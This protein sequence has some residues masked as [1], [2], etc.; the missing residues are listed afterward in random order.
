MKRLLHFVTV[1]FVCK[2]V[3]LEIRGSVM[4]NKLAKVKP[5]GAVVNKK[6]VPLTEFPP[7][8]VPHSHSGR[9]HFED[10]CSK[11]PPAQEVYDGNKVNII[12]DY[13]DDKVAR[14]VAT[15][16]IPDHIDYKHFQVTTQVPYLT[17]G[18]I[19]A[20]GYHPST[21]KSEHPSECEKIYQDHIA[22]MYSD[23]TTDYSEESL[24]MAKMP[25]QPM[26]SSLEQRLNYMYDNV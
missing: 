13:Y 20:L 18:A 4:I 10:E 23:E 3:T 11:R 12:G 17:L 26:T 22:E 8:H 24:E 6:F 16:I 14:T 5:V 1:F 25:V 9:R 15:V 7:P 2:G 19:E 21:L